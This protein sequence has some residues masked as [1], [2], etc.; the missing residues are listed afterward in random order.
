MLSPRARGGSGERHCAMESPHLQP[1]PESGEGDQAGQRRPHPPVQA[2][3]IRWVGGAGRAGC[4]VWR[5]VAGRSPGRWWVLEKQDLG[6]E[7]EA[8]EARV[9]SCVS[10]GSV[11]F[12]GDWQQTGGCL[13]WR[14]AEP[15]AGL[16][17]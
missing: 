1:S 2:G 5:Q 14:R 16:A 13:G 10:L 11:G 12:L 7:G 9:A 6:W 3:S 15:P 17:E 8:Q 4:R